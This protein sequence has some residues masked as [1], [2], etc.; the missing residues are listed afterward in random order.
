M[1][2]IISKPGRDVARGKDEAH[3]FAYY[4]TMGHRS[5]QEDALAWQ[6]FDEGELGSVTPEQIGHRLWTTYQK[7]NASGFAKENGQKTGTTA[8]TTIIKDNHLITATLGDTVAFAVIY[9]T[10]G[11]VASVQRLNPKTHKPSDT[12]EQKRIKDAGGAILGDYVGF[13]HLVAVSRSLGDFVAQGICADATIDITTLSEDAHHVQIITT[14][15][16]FTDGAGL[17]RQ[18]KE[19]HEA[20]LRE[21]LSAMNGGKPGLLSEETIAERLAEDALTKGS[22]DNISIAV[23]SIKTEGRPATQKAMIGVYDGHGGPALSHFV[24]DHIGDE[25]TRQLALSE[26]AYAAQPESVPSNRA[27]YDRDHVRARNIGAGAGAGAGVGDLPRTSSPPRGQVGTSSVPRVSKQP[28]RA[29]LEALHAALV[30]QINTALESIPGRYNQLKT[31]VTTQ[32]DILI[33]AAKELKERRITVE[34]YGKRCTDAIN[35]CEQSFK[36]FRHES[37][38]YQNYV[39]PLVRKFLS[40]LGGVYREERNLDIQVSSSLRSFSVFKKKVN[41]RQEPEGMISNP[42][43]KK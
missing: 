3:R 38:F 16:G 17:T 8:C 27:I 29:Q 12:D 43:G 42:L 25:L 2:R 10:T 7:L 5:G 6:T 39:G 40:C 13:L 19:G 22:R 20:Y 30:A 21:A 11:A 31:D 32:R 35:A 23:Q 4:E 14:C 37:G 24:A 33:S 28:T 36:G 18:T 41:G 1:P 9:D 26:D 34:V 15:D